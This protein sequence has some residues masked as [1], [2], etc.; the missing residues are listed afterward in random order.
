MTTATGHDGDGDV[1]ESSDDG[2]ATLLLLRESSEDGSLLEK[3]LHGLLVG[4]NRS[5]CC[6]LL[7]QP[8]ECTLVG[9]VLNL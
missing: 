5:R 4:L 1:Y 6:Y 8:V 3:S 2:D 7:L 9:E